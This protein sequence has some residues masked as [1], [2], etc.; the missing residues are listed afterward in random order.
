MADRIILTVRPS[1]FFPQPALLAHQEPVGHLVQSHM[2]VP[3][4]P[5]AD[6]EVVQP[7]VVLGL[8]EDLF[9]TV[10]LPEAADEFR[11]R[12]VLGTCGQAVPALAS[13][14]SLGDDQ[15]F[16][17]PGTALALGGNG[18][19]EGPHFNGALLPVPDMKALP[20]HDGPVAGQFLG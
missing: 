3:A 17:Y 4:V 6:L 20:V 14:E 10:S 12:S 15:G 1:D 9:N 5:G 7:H 13:I 2:V 8:L 16:S 18:E 19:H 11:E